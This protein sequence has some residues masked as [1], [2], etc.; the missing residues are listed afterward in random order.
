[1]KETN[2]LGRQTPKERKD[3]L[4]VKRDRKTERFWH[5]VEFDYM[6]G[7]QTGLL[8]EL[9]ARVWDRLAAEAL[10]LPFCRPAQ[11]PDVRVL[12]G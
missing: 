7:C 10:G 9:S 11:V 12:E 1:M 6:V 2:R 3:E 5:L 8:R 4:M